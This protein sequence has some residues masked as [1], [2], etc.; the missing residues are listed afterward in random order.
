VDRWQYYDYVAPSIAIIDFGSADVNSLPSPE[1]RDQGIRIFA[2]HFIT[3][4]DDHT[5]IDHWMHVRNFAVGDASVDQSMNADFRVAFNEDKGILEQIEVVERERPELTGLRLGI[6][7]P[8][9]KVRRKVEQMAAADTLKSNV[10]QA[11]SS[12]DSMRTA[13]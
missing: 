10:Q 1:D 6:D 5:C 3:P 2:L 13:V 8:L 12:S 11:A 4:V 9:L 7:A